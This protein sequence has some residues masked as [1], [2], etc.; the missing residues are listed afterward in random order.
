MSRH[1]QGR[2][3]V[4]HGMIDVLLPATDAGV[5]AQFTVVL[6]CG[7]VGLLVTRRNR[8]LRLLIVGVTLLLVAL[9]ALRAV[10]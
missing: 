6:G 3:R 4:L 10:H 5:A 1:E 9:M 7:L 8:D 2:S